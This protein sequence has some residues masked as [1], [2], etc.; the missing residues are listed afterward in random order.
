MMPLKARGP[1]GSELPP[2][3]DKWDGYPASR[4]KLVRAITSR[5]LGNVVIASGDA[6]MNGIGTVPVRD[7]EPDG[8]AAATE[9]MASSMSSNGDGAE[10]TPHV[11]RFIDG[12]NPH[13]AMANDLRGYHVHEVRPDR[14]TTD[15][16]AMDQV[17]RRGGHL[18]TLARF[19]V[20]AGQPG[21]KRL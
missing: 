20:V 5:D 2:F 10:L 21:L 12:R 13:L 11:R 15:V 4:Q 9:F 1:D 18:R 8:P 6:H 16:K 17:Q 3:G 19:A 14:W 7:D